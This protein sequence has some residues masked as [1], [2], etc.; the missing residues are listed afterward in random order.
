M[1][2]KRESISK[3]QHRHY[4]PDNIP[5][6]ATCIPDHCCFDGDHGR[7]DLNKEIIHRIF[8]EGGHDVGVLPIH[9]VDVNLSVVDVAT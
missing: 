2:R 1:V 4:I 9:M 6:P 3:T 8:G 5:P 7:G